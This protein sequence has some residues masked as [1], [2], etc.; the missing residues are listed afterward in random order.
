MKKKLLA[1]FAHPDDE[2]FGPGATLAKYARE[3]VEIHILCAT[4]GESGNGT[5]EIKTGELL[6]AA[7]VLGVKEVEFLDFKDGELSNN[8]YHALAEKILNKIKL[9]KP[10]VVITFDLSGCSGHLDHIAVALTTTYAFTRQKIAKKLYYVCGLF[11]GL[12]A[13]T[14]SLFRRKYFIY[15]PPGRASQEITTVIDVS[16]YWEK[17]VEAMQKHKSQIKDLKNLLKMY[18]LLPR[19]ERFILLDEK[20][21]GQKLEENDLFEGIF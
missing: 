2:S 14:A 6:E 1:V 19:E 18:K 11:F 21:A 17:K 20:G 15:I 4:R 10:H 16:G 7:G 12:P 13:K 8:Q 3:G 5:G 9:F